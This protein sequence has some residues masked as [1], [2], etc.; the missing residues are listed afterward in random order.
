MLPVVSGES[1]DV[2][3]YRQTWSPFSGLSAGAFTVFY[4]ADHQ[5]ESDLDGEAKKEKRK[6]KAIFEFGWIS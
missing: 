1:G 3:L 4:R 5:Q 6:Y 2:R